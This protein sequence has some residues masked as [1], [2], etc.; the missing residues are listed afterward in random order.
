[1]QVWAGHLLALRASCLI[2]DGRAKQGTSAQY[3][4]TIA[5]WSNEQSQNRNGMK[6]RASNAP[7]TITNQKN[8]EGQKGDLVAARGDCRWWDVRT[9]KGYSIN[10]CVVSKRIA[11]AIRIRPIP[12][13]ISALTHTHTLYRMLGNIQCVCARARMLL[14]DTMPT[15]DTATNDIAIATSE[16]THVRHTF[17]RTYVHNHGIFDSECGG[18][19]DDDIHVFARSANTHNELLIVARVRIEAARKLS[20]THTHITKGTRVRLPAASFAATSNSE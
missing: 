5:K 20:H 19:D 18:D 17:V 2:C 7:K 9:D 10:D 6:W 12:V 4:I 16:R 1:M 15:A 8:L 13:T 3:W 11:F 14:S